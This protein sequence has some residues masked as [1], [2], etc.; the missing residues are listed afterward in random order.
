MSSSFYIWGK[1]YY[2][3]WGKMQIFKISFLDI[4][5]LID[6]NFVFQNLSYSGIRKLNL[7]DSF[8]TVHIVLWKIE[9]RE[10]W[11]A[12]GSTDHFWASSV[13]PPNHRR[14]IRAPFVICKIGMDYLTGWPNVYGHVSL[15][16]FTISLT[17]STGKCI[18]V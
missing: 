1:N 3:F 14:S 13:L 4:V 9:H 8:N 15:Y 17:V 2:A 10:E 16:L 5:L 7:Y 11:R 6:C 18:Q 12:L